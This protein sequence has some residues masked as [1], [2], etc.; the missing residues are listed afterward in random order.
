M[1]TGIISFFCGILL[2]Q[3]MQNLPGLAWCWGLVIVSFLP[4]IPRRYSYGLLF[5]CGFLWALLRAHWILDSGL[6]SELQGKDLRVT[7]VIASIPLEQAHR[8]RF[9]FDIEQLEYQHQHIRVPGRVRLNWY[10][11]KYPSETTSKFNPHSIKAGQRWQFWVRLKQPHGF[12]NPGGF[13]FEK[14]LYQNRIRATGY[15]RLQAKKNHAAIKLTDI[16]SGYHLLALRQFLHDKVQAATEGMS[17]AGILSAL[18]LGDRAGITQEQWQVFRATGTSHLV[19][20]SGLHIGLLAGLV[21]FLTLVLW[22]RLLS[23]AALI[24]AA[25]RAA[26][27]SSLFAAFFYAALSG[28]GIPAQRALM[29]LFI[30]MLAVFRRKKAQ[31][32]HVLALALLGVLLLDPVSVLSPGF[33]LSFA[34]VTIITLA[35]AGRLSFGQRWLL[36]GRTQWRISV[37]LIP[38]LLFLFQQASLVSPL[39]NLFAIPLIS[40]LVVPL[41]LLATLILAV[42]PA[43]STA[44][45]GLADHILTLLWAFLSHLSAYSWGQW[46]MAK[47]DV[48]SLVLAILGFALLLTPKGWPA[49]SLGIIM[50][51]PLFFTK[52]SVIPITQAKVTLLDVGQ[53]LSAVIQTRQHVLLFDTGPKFSDDFDTGA[54]VVVPFL[55][56]QGIRELDMVILSHK[57]NDHRGGFDSIQ[58]AVKARQILSSY[59]EAGSEACHAGQ[60]WQ[61]DGVQFEI[62]NPEL[63]ALDHKRNNNS[64]V[65]WLTADGQSVLFP[66]DIEARAE[67]R[68]LKSKDGQLQARYLIVPHHGSKTSSSSLFLKAV[69]PQYALIPVGYRNRYSMPHLKVMQRYAQHG[70]KTRLT[71][72]SGALELLLGEKSTNQGPV[73]YRQQVQKY[74]NSRH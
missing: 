48:V 17:F 37:A 38:L 11:K 68:L 2:L 67:K 7:G 18:A 51:L 22:P 73:G 40:F 70:I 16:A 13:D 41:V 26:A 50:L 4:F 12:M 52:T 63:T 62:L 3:Q 53:G 49:K 64:C 27:I 54:A 21:Y 60:S 74:W 59:H 6:P 25:P 66:A 47:P 69:N 55:L 14:W 46:V 29:M 30:V 39:A 5:V 57:D 65:L 44:F 32:S 10:L 72:A 33:W 23:S 28:F 15:V 9:E 58:K 56:E 34:A 45:Y 1:I 35:A 19:A 20:I 36:W 71:F 61:W 8:R 31:A 24:L 43:I 42:T